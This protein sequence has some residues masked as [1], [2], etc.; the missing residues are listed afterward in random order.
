MDGDTVRA[1]EAA[2][3]LR[4]LVA[5]IETGELTGSPLLVARLE[6]AIVA[7]EALASGRQL[8]AD[9]FQS[10]VGR[11]RQPEGC[12]NSSPPHSTSRVPT[13]V[14]MRELDGQRAECRELLA[15]PRRRG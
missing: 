6:G 5:A 14:P 1:A 7:L 11:G 2:A 8:T 15:G 12:T 4:A 9:D 3:T 10:P 13:K